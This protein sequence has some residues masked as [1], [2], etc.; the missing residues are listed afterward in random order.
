M[1]GKNGS[2]SSSAQLLKMKEEKQKD[3]RDRKGK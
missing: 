3:I 2:R 1:V